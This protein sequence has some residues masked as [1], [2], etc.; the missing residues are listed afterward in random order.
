MIGTHLRRKRDR[1]TFRVVGRDGGH[2]VIAPDDFGSPLSVS[3]LEIREL[4]EVIGDEPD[5]AGVEPSAHVAGRSAEE[6][7]GYETLA[8]QS[9]EAFAAS[10]RKRT[11]SPA[12]TPEQVFS[13][14]D[15]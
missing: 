13:R 4:Y 7:A 12:L 2:W 3:E 10:K 15:S 9:F 8:A 6:Q 5:T 14:D 11:G 1:A